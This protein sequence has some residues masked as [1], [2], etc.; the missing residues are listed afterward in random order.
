[1]KR[2]QVLQ[3]LK[4]AEVALRAQGVAHA[5]LFGSVARDEQ[6]P[7]SDI[8]IMLELDPAAHVD[9]FT[10]IGVQEYVASLF[11]GSVDVVN[12]EGLKPDLRP[13]ATAEAIYAF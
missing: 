12:L 4:E 10:Y 8:D 9:L 6:R 13:R 11:S 3:T 7:D 5:A 2:D 1:M